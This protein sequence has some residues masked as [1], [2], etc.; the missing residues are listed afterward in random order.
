[1]TLSRRVFCLSERFS[2]MRAQSNESHFERPETS[3]TL[4]A[5][6]VVS[7]PGKRVL[8]AGQKLGVS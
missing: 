5:L 2:R 6:A 8:L 7:I 1:M 3:V 4:F